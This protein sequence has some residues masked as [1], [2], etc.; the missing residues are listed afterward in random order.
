MYAVVM[1]SMYN[2]YAVVMGR[3]L[4]LSLSLFIIRVFRLERS[5]WSLVL[6]V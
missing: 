5:H 4:F 1:E 3:M 2:M 6:T